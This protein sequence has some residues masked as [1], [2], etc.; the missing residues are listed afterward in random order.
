MTDHNIFFKIFDNFMEK[1]VIHA[2]ILL[3]TWWNRGITY[4]AIFLTIFN[5]VSLSL[6]WRPILIT[7][8]I[9]TWVFYVIVPTVVVSFTLFI[10]YYDTVKKIWLRETDIMNQNANPYHESFNKMFKEV[11]EINEMLKSK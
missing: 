6:L 1:G 10:G 3:K 8:G 11:S 7:Y 9:P 4:V 5:L 2:F